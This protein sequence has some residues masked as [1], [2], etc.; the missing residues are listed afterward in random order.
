MKMDK[1]TSNIIKL[2]KYELSFSNTEL[3]D[4]EQLKELVSDLE[5]H[6]STSL[7]DNPKE[8]KRLT[9]EYLYLGELL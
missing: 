9:D 1:I 3:V 4:I 2:I 6:L 8:V 5:V 7:H